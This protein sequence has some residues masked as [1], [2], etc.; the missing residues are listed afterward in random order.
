MPAHIISTLCHSQV[1]HILSCKTAPALAAADAQ[2]GA[3]NRPHGAGDNAVDDIILASTLWLRCEARQHGRVKGMHPEQGMQL[4]WCR[5]FP[6]TKKGGRGMWTSRRDLQRLPLWAGLWWLW[7]TFLT[8]FSG[9][10]SYKHAACGTS[11][12]TIRQ[13]LRVI[14]RN[15]HSLLEMMSKPAIQ[16]QLQ[17]HLAVPVT[18]HLVQKML[19]G[20]IQE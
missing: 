1:V 9:D 10:G 3:A 7:G 11:D 12:A 17:A 5:A 15:R 2:P 8:S 18:S 16:L 4:L 19:G 13:P 14:K 20:F 6:P